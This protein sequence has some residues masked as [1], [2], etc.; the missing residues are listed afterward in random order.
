MMVV[1]TIPESERIISIGLEQ[2]SL[3]IEYEFWTDNAI[4]NRIEDANLYISVIN[5]FRNYGYPMFSYKLSP[6]TFKIS[7]KVIT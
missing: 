6:I 1:L 3:I 5:V 7:T 4:T 2:V